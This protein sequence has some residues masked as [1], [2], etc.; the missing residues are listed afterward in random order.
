MYILYVQLIPGSIYF[1][2]LIS[3]RSIRL[4]NR[5]MEKPEPSRDCELFLTSFNLLAE[6]ISK[7]RFV[8]DDGFPLAKGRSSTVEAILENSFPLN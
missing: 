2:V 6:N 3:S 8:A 5:D 7:P 4:E 1:Q